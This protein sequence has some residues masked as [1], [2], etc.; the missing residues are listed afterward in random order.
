M[1]R[2]RLIATVVVLLALTG[3]ATWWFTRTRPVT[4]EDLQGEWV[5]DPDFVQHVGSDLEAQRKEL[6]HYEDYQFAFR[7]AKLTGYRLI[8]DGTKTDSVGWS[9]GQ[10]VT[11]ES[12]FTLAPAKAA[13]LLKFQDHTKSP[14]EAQLAWE[15]DKLTVSLGDRK[16][17]L[18]KSP[19]D[20]LRSRK[21]I[22]AP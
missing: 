22:A 3:A 13:T 1:P 19:A 2:S 8:H 7:G 14:R 6:E 16:F 17:R 9:I 21:L 10:S 5:Q 11:F 20:Q 15:K 18:V 4:A 12:D